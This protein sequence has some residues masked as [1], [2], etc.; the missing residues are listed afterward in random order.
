MKC[1]WLS[2]NWVYCLPSSWLQ[3][4]S[5]LKAKSHHPLVKVW[6]QSSLARISSADK[7]QDAQ[8]TAGLD[9]EHLSYA[10]LKYLVE[11]DLC[12]EPSSAKINMN[13]CITKRDTQRQVISAQSG[14]WAQGIKEGVVCVRGVSGLRRQEEWRLPGSRGRTRERG[15]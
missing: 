12:W 15:G 7:T 8:I 14:H 13:L 5:W 6:Q 4:N 9:A 1:S 10:S 11:S 3:F 2:C